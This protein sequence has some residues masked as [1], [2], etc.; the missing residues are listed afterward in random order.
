MWMMRRSQTSKM[1]Q[2]PGGSYGMCDE[3]FIKIEK[4]AIKFCNS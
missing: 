4:N 2:I 3:A 1:A